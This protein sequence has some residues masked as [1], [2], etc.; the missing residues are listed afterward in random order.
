MSA[1]N[2][3]ID[4]EKCV[5]CGK[6]SKDC[7]SQIIKINSKNF[8]TINA[9]DEKF[10]IKC[11]HCLAI[12]PVGAIS[13]LN[14]TPKNSE[15]CE[16]F[17]SDEQ[18][19]KLIKS[20]RS[21]R[22]YEPENLPL[23]TMEKLKNMLKYPPTGCNHHKL[24]FSIIEDVEVMNRFRNRTNNKI[25]K[26]F[27][28]AGENIVTKK[29]ARYKKAFL[30][31]NDVIYRN[32]PHLIVVSS[33][34]NAPCANEDG[35]ISLSYFELYAQ[36]LGVGT[37]WCGFAQLCLKIFP[38]LCEFL[39]IPDN[40]KPVYVMLFG[41]TKTKYVRTTQPEEYDITTVKGDKNVD[42]I[43]LSRKLKRYLWNTIR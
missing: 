5:R 20:R 10:C 28:A 21:I 6:C 25:K 17:P 18:L 37:L 14:K 32:A 4:K 35:I 12:C 2:F 13:I 34:I 39:E 27:L 40:Y 41:S 33:P 38:D 31:G 7:V 19:L 3:E 15:I 16:N 8:P 29:F 36:S 30:E 24:H 22:H 23:E 26:M 11:Q 43:P 9:V 1:I 42:N